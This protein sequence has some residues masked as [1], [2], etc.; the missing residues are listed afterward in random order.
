[1]CLSFLIF[2]FFTLFFYCKPSEKKREASKFKNRKNKHDNESPHSSTSELLKKNFISPGVSEEDF[3]HPKMAFHLGYS[4]KVKRKGKKEQKNQNGKS[5][6][7]QPQ[8]I[9]DKAQKGHDLDKEREALDE[10]NMQE[11]KSIKQVSRN[12]ETINDPTKEIN[13]EYGTNKKRPE[14]KDR[15]EGCRKLSDKP[16]VV[17]GELQ[18]KDGVQVSAEK[19]VSKDHMD[20]KT[21]DKRRFHPPGK[22]LNCSEPPS[23]GTKFAKDSWDT[24]QSCTKSERA[25]SQ[26]DP[27]KRVNSPVQ[28]VADISENHESKSYGG[29]KMVNEREETKFNPSTSDKDNNVSRSPAGK[30]AVCF[31]ERTT[32]TNKHKRNHVL[33]KLPSFDD[34][35][36]SNSGFLYIETSHETNDLDHGVVEETQCDKPTQQSQ[37]NVNSSPPIEPTQW[38]EINKPN[39]VHEQEQSK[40]KGKA[41]LPAIYGFEEDELNASGDY[42]F[43]TELQVSSNMES[44]YVFNKSCFQKNNANTAKALDHCAIMSP[45]IQDLSY[46]ECGKNDCDQTKKIEPRNLTKEIKGKQNKNYDKALSIPAGG[47]G[48]GVEILECPEGYGSGRLLRQLRERNKKVSYKEWES[49]E[50]S[51]NEKKTHQSTKLSYPCSVGDEFKEAQASLEMS[52]SDDKRKSQNDQRSMKIFGS[53]APKKAPKESSRQRRT[54]WT[55]KEI[56]TTVTTM[57]YSKTVQGN[58]SDPYNFEADCATTSTEAAP[59]APFRSF[60]LNKDSLNLTQDV[61]N[62]HVVEGKRDFSLKTKRSNKKARQEN[63]S[64]VGFEKASTQH[65]SQLCTTSCA[66]KSEALKFGKKKKKACAKESEEFTLFS[67]QRDVKKRKEKKSN[68]IESM[69]FTLFSSQK[70]Q[71]SL[72]FYFVAYSSIAVQILTKK[73]TAI[74]TELFIVQA[75]PFDALSAKAGMTHAKSITRRYHDV[76]IFFN[77]SYKV[78]RK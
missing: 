18:Q 45:S 74:I 70:S 68:T 17:E 39:K 75:N 44:S 21:K 11:S 5:T 6:S 19:I 16:E 28:T 7:R 43:S 38:Q 46:A 57:S 1:M 65:K 20:D 61:Q 77:Y 32:K 10:R 15:S 47:C 24:S 36:S 2:F 55:S 26:K 27:T 35:S 71:V 60:S 72:F 64:K 34:V 56:K 66:K 67:S 3:K 73:T 59:L 51:D 37:D 13:Y 69:E 76:L 54:F 49:F 58:D 23:Q 29:D 53:M 42:N 50:A 30:R 52:P 31:Q 12:A 41:N 78:Y 62:Q 33:M 9:D 40:I 22:K 25:F 14:Q 8:P 63:Y 4:K 48:D